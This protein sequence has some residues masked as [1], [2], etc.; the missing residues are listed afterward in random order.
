MS[1]TPRDQELWGA[2]VEA[3]RQLRRRQ[4]AFYQQAGD[5]EAVLRAALEPGA[6]AWQQGTAL[7][8]LQ[9][10]G[11][12]AAPL[13]P[14]LVSLAV[15]S[16]KW[17]RQPIEII[18]QIPCDQCMPL[19]EPIF[20]KYLAAAETGNDY[21]DLAYLAVRCEAWTLLQRLVQQTVDHDDP[22]VRD[23]VAHYS[24]RYLATASGTGG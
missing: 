20:L 10:F 23:V 7:D 11:G 18:A 16:D 8:Y 13:L 21:A 14:E 4:A 22:D 6:G 15:M 17:G 9:G 3:E 5:R 12:D 19:L 24:E 2:C 1:S